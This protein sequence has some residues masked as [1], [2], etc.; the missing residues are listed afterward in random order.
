MSAYR[1]LGLTVPITEVLDPQKWRERYAY[2]L[3]IKDPSVG[4]TS[5]SAD[6]HAL[7]CPDPDQPQTAGARDAQA[8]AQ[9]ELT[10]LVQGLPDETI[11][12]H[13]RAALSEVELHLGV[14]MGTVVV[15]S[16]PV[17]EGLV[18]GVHYDKAE[19]RRPFVRSS[20]ENWWKFDLP[21][22]VISIER[23]RAYWFD[24]LV[25]E[26]SNEQNNIDLIK[27]EWPDQGATHIIPSQ[28][29]NLLITAPG[30]T[31]AWGT[32]NYGAFQMVHGGF[33]AQRLPNV[34]GFDYTIGPFD[35]QTGTVGHIEAVIANWVY[36]TAGILLLSLEGM[37]RSQGVSNA[38]IS[39][40]GLSR[41]IGTTASAIY[42][43]NSALENALE[44]ATK[45]I[46]WKA[47]KIYK[48]GLRIRPYGH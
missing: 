43:L 42:G 10:E 12:W 23:V 5:N 16:P 28:G 15:K 36:C 17:D 2:G 46:D 20:Q 33:G 38:S 4:A 24:V 44:K 47:L 11:R 14:P 19:P 30:F 18:Q 3:F 41:S 40:D 29:F 37:A 35:K 34:W 1:T 9:A 25:W 26:I 48:R 45:R 32:G 6:L 27:L 13:L 22:G 39:I 8:D 7:L 21:S 31:G